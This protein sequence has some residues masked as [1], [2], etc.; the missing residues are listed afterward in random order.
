MQAESQK[1]PIGHDATGNVHRHP[2]PPDLA[3]E[4]HRAEQ[5]SELSELAGLGTS[6]LE[7]QASRRQVHG[8]DGDRQQK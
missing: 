5:G 4:R 3:G 7:R 2:S 8:Q 6:P 1:I